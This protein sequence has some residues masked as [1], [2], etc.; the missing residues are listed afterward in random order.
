[1]TPD[2]HPGIR[3]GCLDYYGHPLFDCYEVRT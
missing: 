2:E 1:M 3:T